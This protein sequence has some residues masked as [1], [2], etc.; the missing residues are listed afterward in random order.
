MKLSSFFL[1]ACGTAASQG[2]ITLLTDDFSYPDGNLVGNGSWTIHSGSANFIQVTSGALVMSHGSGSR[3]D[4]GAT[5]ADTGSGIL[6]AEFD[7]TVADDSVITGGDYEY[8]AHFMTEGEFNFRAR[9]DI[10][11]GQS[12]GDFTLG[13]DDASSAASVIFGSDLSFGV[14]YRVAMTYSLD[15]GTAS[16]TV[17]GAGLITAAADE[18]PETTTNRFAFR[19]SNSSNDETITVDNLVVSSIPEPSSALLS[20]LALLGFLRRKR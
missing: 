10:V 12:G 11:E 1:F 18:A 19:Q 5:F 3:E 14:T 17:D 6:T 8:F 9:L 2:S 15:D 13:L 7:L 20:G 16:L 4:A